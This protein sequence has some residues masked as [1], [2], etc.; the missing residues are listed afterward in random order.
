MV[1]AMKGSKEKVVRSAGPGS[2]KRDLYPGPA[3]RVSSLSW[4]SWRSWRPCWAM[5]ALA[6]AA[7]WRRGVTAALVLLVAFAF[8]RRACL[9]GLWEGVRSSSR[10]L[11]SSG[12]VSAASSSDE[13]RLIRGRLQGVRPPREEGVGLDGVVVVLVVAAV[14]VVDVE[15]GRQLAT[16]PPEVCTARSVSA[17]FL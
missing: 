12:P 7:A 3:E 13:E 11:Q 10:S 17:S 16:S 15:S 4:A 2:P 14:V 9:D 5:V 6:L 1:V 8:A